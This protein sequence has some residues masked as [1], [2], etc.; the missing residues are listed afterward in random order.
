MPEAERTL[1]SARERSRDAAHDDAVAA[2]AGEEADVGVAAER[3]VH[4]AAV[5]AERL[6][7][8]QAHL[9]RFVE[10]RRLRAEPDVLALDHAICSCRSS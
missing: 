8:S 4:D 1:D 5:N 6:A 10:G 9:A 7:Y 3:A 2:A